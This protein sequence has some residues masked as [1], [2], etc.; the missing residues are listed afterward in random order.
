[1]RG[2]DAA[3]LA[4]VVA[5]AGFAAADAI[6]GHK[7][8]KGGRTTSER[9]ERAA[10]SSVP[11]RL[12]AA[13]STFDG[14][15]LPGSLVFTDGGCRLRVIGR[16]AEALRSAPHF[17]G[18]CTLSAPPTGQFVAY[19]LAGGRPGRVPF[20][21]LDLRDASR[22]VATFAARSRALAWSP[23]GRRLA[24]CDEQGEGRELALDRGTVGRL[25]ACPATYTPQG[26]PAYANGG[27]LVV[28][29]RTVARV[30]GQI[31]FARWASDGSLALVVDGARIE[32]WQ[33]GRRT[34]AR[35]T[36][37][38][39]VYLDTAHPAFS[40][41]NCAALFPALDGTSVEVVGFRCF[42]WAN[43]NVPVPGSSA[44]WSPDGEWIAATDHERILLVEGPFASVEDVRI[45]AVSLAWVS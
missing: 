31:T 37:V 22:P 5:V 38:R 4:A 14:R 18:D 42:D 40:P 33:D 9:A 13:A 15:L 20:G 1:V 29:G 3:L 19:G 25:P 28:G 44:A 36:D 32:R 7:S 30:S 2:R 35:G 17:T 27:R 24:W 11:D 21:V 23:D 43:K 6:R 26:E 12:A 10:P 8:E 34:D 16:F 39:G 45:G 41:D